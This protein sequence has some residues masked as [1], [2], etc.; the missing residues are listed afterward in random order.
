MD[1]LDKIIGIKDFSLLT[2]EESYLYKE[3]SHNCLTYISWEREILRIQR[4][5]IYKECL[6]HYTALH[7]APAHNMAA[8]AQNK[9]LE[10]AA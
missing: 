8:S 7:K 1:V 6:H 10:L 5:I 2:N 3:S 4:K 9:R